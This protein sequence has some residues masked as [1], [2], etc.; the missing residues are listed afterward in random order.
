MIV[1]RPFFFDGKSRR[2]HQFVGILVYRNPTPLDQLWRN[3][4]THDVNSNE[5]IVECAS[6]S[7]TYI[8]IL[9]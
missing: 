8:P 4:V 7:R 9:N 5:M 2:G 3:N 1:K 6:M